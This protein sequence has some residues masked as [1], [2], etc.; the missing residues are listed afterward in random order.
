MEGFPEEFEQSPLNPIE[1]DFDWA[2]AEK[3]KAS[4]VA[5]SFDAIE[6]DSRPTIEVVAAE[7]RHLQNMYRE[8][9]LDQSQSLEDRK[10]ARSKMFFH[11]SHAA[12]LERKI[13]GL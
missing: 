11:I 5:Y 6:P 1:S 8:Q 10:T 12:A 3:I 13:R 7:H 9:Y 2:V 4:E